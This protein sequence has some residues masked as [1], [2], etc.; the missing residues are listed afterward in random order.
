MSAHTNTHTHTHC[1]FHFFAICLHNV[2]HTHTCTHTYTHI[3]HGNLT[4]LTGLMNQKE[5]LSR[6][7]NLII[8]YSIGFV[9]Y[10]QNMIPY[11]FLFVLGWNMSWKSSWQ[12]HSTAHWLGGIRSPL[13]MSQ[14][15]LCLN[16]NIDMRS[17][18]PTQPDW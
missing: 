3:D 16:S 7:N 4:R 5:I 13:Q 6:F 1:V 2:N 17:V 10:M 11:F 8:F 14:E 9:F 15:Q 18:P 12:V